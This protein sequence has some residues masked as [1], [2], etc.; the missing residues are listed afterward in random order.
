MFSLVLSISGL[1]Q[2]L[3]GGFSESRLL[4]EKKVEDSRA[5]PGSAPGKA[6]VEPGFVYGAVVSDALAKRCE[7]VRRYSTL[8]I[9][10]VDSAGSARSGAGVVVSADSVVTVWHVVALDVKIT[11]RFADGREFP[12]QVVTH[13]AAQDLAVLRSPKSFVPDYRPV[14]LASVEAGRV[15][16]CAIGSPYGIPLLVSYGQV[17]ERLGNGDLLLS[18][19][20]LYP[21][22]SGGPLINEGGYLVGVNKSLLHFQVGRVSSTGLVDPAVEK[23]WQLIY[24]GAGLAVSAESIAPL[25]HATVPHK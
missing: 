2:F 7:E 19:H 6:K 14:P 13:D 18:K 9:E 3:V 23:Y 4:V 11:G 20:F 25:V 8:Q 1:Y 10:A 22:N 5:G 21:G 16:V 12:L 24:E 17:E 15:A